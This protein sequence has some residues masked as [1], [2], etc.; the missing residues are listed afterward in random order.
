MSCGRCR[1]ALGIWAEH[2]Q[3]QLHGA[4][5]E[6]DPETAGEN[7][8][9]GRHGSNSPGYAPLYGGQEQYPNNFAGW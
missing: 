4:K 3:E 2:M 5:R 1:G 8:G 6:E 9:R 7:A